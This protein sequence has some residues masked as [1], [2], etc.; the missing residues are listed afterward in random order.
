VRIVRPG[1]YLPFHVELANTSYDIT[2]I[3]PSPNNIVAEIGGAYYITHV[4]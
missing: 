4:I 3:R 1:W 2:V